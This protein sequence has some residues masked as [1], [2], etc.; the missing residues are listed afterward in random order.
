MAT[1]LGVTGT[2]VEY[3]LLW[4]VAMGVPV[5]GIGLFGWPS[6][7]LLSLLGVVVAGRAM[8]LVWT[9]G[10]PGQ[11]AQALP[12]TAAGLMTYATGFAVGLV[13]G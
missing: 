5:V 7:V 10:T 6:T 4:A 13:L 1:R 8:R 9:A 3:T 12:P 2:R 11:V